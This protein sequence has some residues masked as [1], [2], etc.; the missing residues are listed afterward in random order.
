MSGDGILQN[1]IALD[2]AT[3]EAIPPFSCLDGYK[4]SI[5]QIEASKYLILNDS[6]SQLLGQHTLPSTN[7]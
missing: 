1:S 2:R 6:I 7:Q 4:N 5:Q 3:G